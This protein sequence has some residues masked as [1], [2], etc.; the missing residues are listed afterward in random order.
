MLHCYEFDTPADGFRRFFFTRYAAFDIY[1]APAASVVNS[2]RI[3]LHNNHSQCHE[4]GDEAD[5]AILRHLRHAFQPLSI[6]P[7][8]LRF[9][10]CRCFDA[11]LPLMMP[12]ASYAMLAIAAM[13]Y[14]LPLFFFAMFCHAYATLLMFCYARCRCCCRHAA[15]YVSCRRC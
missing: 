14:M 15:D 12:H 8:S 13:R 2:R 9:A 11:T 4:R 1:A 6:T 3:I 5:Y 10:A 7:L